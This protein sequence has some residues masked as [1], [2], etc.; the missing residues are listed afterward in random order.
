[1]SLYNAQF[2]ANIKERGFCVAN[3]NMDAGKILRHDKARE[4]VDTAKV[5]R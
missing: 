5:Y 3:D 4:K 2:F 1:M